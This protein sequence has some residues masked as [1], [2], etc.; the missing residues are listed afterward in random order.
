MD[1]SEC[2]EDARKDAPDGKG[3]FLFRRK[4]FSALPSVLRVKILQRICFDRLGVAPNERLLKAMDGNV[5]NGGPSARVNAGKG[6]KLANRYEEALFVPGEY[7]VDRKPARS[8]SGKDMPILIAAPGE[9]DI[10]LGRQGRIVTLA[11]EAKGKNDPGAGEAPRGEG[12]RRGV[13][14]GRPGVAARGSALAGR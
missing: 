7:E 2:E 12:R 14:R 4:T 3:G 6:W 10:P 5:C 8:V 9:Y 1:P 11:W 13:R